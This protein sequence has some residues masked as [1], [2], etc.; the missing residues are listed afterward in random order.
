MLG[1][2][3]RFFAPR[4]QIPPVAYSALLS[5]QHCLLFLPPEHPFAGTGREIALDGITKL[6]E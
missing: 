6:L 4:L 3:Q 2:F 1:H 5:T